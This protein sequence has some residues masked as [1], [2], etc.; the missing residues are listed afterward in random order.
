MTSSKA[1]KVLGWLVGIS[2]INTL[3]KSY[4]PG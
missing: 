3:A 1:L 2:Q 4:D